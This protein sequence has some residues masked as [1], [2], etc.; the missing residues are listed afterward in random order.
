MYL[1]TAFITSKKL[2]FGKKLFQIK[3]NHKLN[4]IQKA[5]LTC[6]T[7]TDIAL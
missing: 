7:D 4:V 5:L 6:L 2:S 3:K 1:K